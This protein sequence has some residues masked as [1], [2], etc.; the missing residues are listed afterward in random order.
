MATI[1]TCRKTC[2]SDILA[3][4]QDLSLP[5]A[6]KANA[7][8]WARLQEELDR[9]AAADRDLAAGTTVPTVLGA[10]RPNDPRVQPGVAS[11]RWLGYAIGWSA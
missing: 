10:L 1:R 5:I 9:L 11:R 7:S 3:F 8:D 2:G 4:Y 6:T